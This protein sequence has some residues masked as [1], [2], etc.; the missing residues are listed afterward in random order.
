LE[1]SAFFHL[2]HHREKEAAALYQKLVKRDP[3]NVRA[4]SGLIKAST[5]F[6]SDQAGKYPFMPIFRSF[7]FLFFFLPR[8]DADGDSLESLP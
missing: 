4:I 3:S 8:A 5:F 1:F 6:D 2:K 7:H